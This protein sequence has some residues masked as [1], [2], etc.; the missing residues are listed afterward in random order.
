MTMMMGT[1]VAVGLSLAALLLLTSATAALEDCQ[2]DGGQQVIQKNCRWKAAAG[3]GDVVLDGPP[4]GI[5]STPPMLLVNSVG[6]AVPPKAIAGQVFS[7]KIAYAGSLTAFYL[8]LLHP[9]AHVA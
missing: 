6:A 5:G 2:Y 7:P 3:S 1:A 9:G 8:H 4:A